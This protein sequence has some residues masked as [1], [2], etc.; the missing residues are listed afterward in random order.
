MKG[1]GEGRGAAF[2]LRRAQWC[3]VCILGN[4]EAA[5]LVSQGAS[6][7]ENAVL[8][9]AWLGALISCVL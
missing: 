4:L 9:R 5:S 3:N 7:G 6:Q 2:R 1:V 8:V